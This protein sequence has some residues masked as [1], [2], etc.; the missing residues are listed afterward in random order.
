MSVANQK[1]G[2]KMVSGLDAQKKSLFCALNFPLS[3]GQFRPILRD[4]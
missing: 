4:L 2:G 3:G 1:L